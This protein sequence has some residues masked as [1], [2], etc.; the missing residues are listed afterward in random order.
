MAKVC[1]HQWDPRAGP[2]GIYIGVAVYGLEEGM[3]VPKGTVIECRDCTLCHMAQGRQ[4]DPQGPWFDL[5]I[6]ADGP[7]KE[8]V[9]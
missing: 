9:A 3:G 8:V 7:I 4:G 5:G 1:E 6:W 2:E